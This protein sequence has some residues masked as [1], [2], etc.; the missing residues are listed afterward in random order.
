MIVRNRCPAPGVGAAKAAI[1]VAIAGDRRASGCRDAVAIGDG[2][3]RG[4]GQWRHGRSVEIV[5]FH[6]P[7]QCHTGQGARHPLLAFKLPSQW[8]AG[9]ALYQASRRPA[10]TW[11]RAPAN[12]AIPT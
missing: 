10:A 8:K 6:R 1:I 3:L 2:A 11:D 12:D 7:S 9:A 5:G 4:V